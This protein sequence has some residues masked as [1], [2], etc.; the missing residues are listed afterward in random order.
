MSANS[1]RIKEILKIRANEGGIVAL[2]ASLMMCVSAGAAIG[3]PGIES[4]FLSRF[5][6]QFLPYMYVVLGVVIAF[7]SLGITGLLGRLDSQLIYV[8]LPL[9]MALILVAARLMTGLDIHWFYPV[10]WLG[11]N[12]YWAL[13]NLFTWGLAGTVFDTRQAKRLFPLF[14]AGGI[15][16]LTFGGLLTKPLVDWLGTEN[17]LWVWSLS[18]IAALFL[19]KRIIRYRLPEKK[20]S[21]RNRNSLFNEVKRGFYYTRR[22]SLLRW[23]ALAAVLFSL[24]YYSVVFPFARAVTAEFI[25]EDDLTAFLGV[26]QGI[27]MGAT[28]LTALFISNRLYAHLGFM[29][30]I[31]AYPVL[32]FLGFTSLTIASVFPVLVIFRFLQLLWG[33]G[34]SEGA[35]HAMYNL[36]PAGQREQTRTFVRGVANPI[37]VS[38]VGVILITSELLAPPRLIYIL[39][40][41]AAAIAAILVWLAKQR[42]GQALI[43]ALQSGQ[44]QL[45]FSDDDED[46]PF[47]GFK[48]DATAIETLIEGISSADTTVRRV[49]AEILVKLQLNEA[50]DAIVSGLKDNDAYVRA[51][52]LRAVARNDIKSAISHVVSALNDPKSQVRYEAVH[53]LTSLQRPRQE[54]VEYLAPMLE[55]PDPKVRILVAVSLLAEG[56]HQKA[57]RVFRDLVAH[58]D[59]PV[60]LEALRALK[61]WGSQ[62]AY[63][64]ADECLNDPHPA[65]RQQAAIILAQIDPE[66]C[67]YSLVS[68]LGDED[69]AVKKT[70]AIALGELGERAVQ[71]VLSALFNPSFEEGA[72]I[73]FDHLP[74]NIKLNDQIILDYIQSQVKNALY[75]HNLWISSKGEKHSSES[76]QLIKDLLREKSIYHG[77]NSLKAM[78]ILENGFGIRLAMKNLTSD[79]LDQRAYAL[80]VLD[81]LGNS[82]LV[83]PLM[84]I[85]EL[86]DGTKLVKGD[87]IFQVMKSDDPWLR[88]SA[89]LAAGDIAGLDVKPIVKQL[90]DSDPEELVRSA[91]RK[92]LS[93]DSNM[94]TLQTLTQMERILFLRQVFLFSNLTLSDIK[95]IASIAEEH[96]FTDGEI[97]AEEGEMGEEMY[98]I[99]SGEVKVVTGFQEGNEMEIAR[100][101][102]GEAVGE[103]SIINK[104]PRIASL[105]AYGEVRTLCINQQDFEEIL[106]TQPETS[107]AV[108]RVLCNRIKEQI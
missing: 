72:L 99:V 21:N 4:L 32:Y 43:E 29:F 101:V 80:E 10:L 97:I 71:P 98:L 46:E 107:L 41:V 58:G 24:L 73:T 74:K 18:L 69:S 64:I 22:S 55:D 14:G 28:F 30:A 86:E 103:M 79:S 45:Y 5:G 39:G 40:M 17:L 78:A 8:R 13:L 96:L 27:S 70:S 63:Q 2:V 82:E 60:R 75:F 100:R 23:M 89:V 42:Y 9:V 61:S 84:A 65:I 95:R 106:R 31:L 54:I 94:K 92:T 88:A 59:I 76:I 12:V 6:V 50:T 37:G 53:A 81:T 47:G 16:G 36:V 102:T 68:L 11:M 87:W 52:L 26:F 66:Q 48:Q 56:D 19:A 25:L 44:S 105:I 38:L 108:M 104:E 62:T 67:V 33:E 93:G 51:S 20:A 49:S 35:N 3:S 34:I 83:R 91:A 90:A 85:W 1:T 7:T 15:L 77:I 57:D